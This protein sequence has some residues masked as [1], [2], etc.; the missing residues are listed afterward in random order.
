MAKIASFRP[1]HKIF[2]GF[3]ARSEFKKIQKKVYKSNLT[4]IIGRGVIS[5]KVR[6]QPTLLLTKHVGSGLA[7]KLSTGM[8]LLD[9]E[10]AFK[11]VCCFINLPFS[12]GV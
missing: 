5:K 11:C 12:Y 2:S 1:N 9:V 7:A 8:L 3:V 6:F 10:K 4:K